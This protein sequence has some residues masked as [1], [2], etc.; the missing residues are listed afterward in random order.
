MDETKLALDRSVQ[1]WQRIAKAKDLSEV[2]IDEPCPLCLLFREGG[3]KGCPIADMTG[4]TGCKGTNHQAA[5]DAYLDAGIKAQIMPLLGH[6]EHAD[7]A[8]AEFRRQSLIY[9]GEIE[10]A[11]DAWLKR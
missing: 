8:M 4:K 9:A 2:G 10:K 11:R 1:R 5:I 7:E 6:S 3:C